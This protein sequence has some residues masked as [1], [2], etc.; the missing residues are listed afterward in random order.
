MNTIHLHHSLQQEFGGPFEYAVRSPREA[1]R[2]LNA[3]YPGFAERLAQMELK[4]I[5]TKKGAGRAIELDETEIGLQLAASEIHIVP[6]PAGSKRGGLGKIIL[7][8]ALIGAVLVTGGAALVGAGAMSVGGAIGAV[9]ILGVSGGSLALMGAA[10]VVGGVASM[11]APTPKG[12]G[13]NEQQ[14]Q[15][16]S[17]LFNQA[18]NVDAQG[19]AVP[20]VIGTFRTGSVVGAS[21]LTVEKIAVPSGSSTDATQGNTGYADWVLGH[22]ILN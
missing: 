6:M 19:N 12:I 4:L 13:P 5:V 11:L 21:S 22:V 14:D 10:M 17:F 18:V 1:V 8:I 7:G 20:V 9:S 15:K 2:A 16:T 3:N